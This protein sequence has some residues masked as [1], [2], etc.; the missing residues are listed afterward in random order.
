MEHR[1]TR[2][3]LRN[4]VEEGGKNGLIWAVF[5]SSC[6]KNEQDVR[7]M[8]TA[9]TSVLRALT[10]LGPVLDFLWVLVVL[11]GNVPWLHTRTLQPRSIERRVL[12]QRRSQT[13]RKVV[14]KKR[15]LQIAKGY[16]GRQNLHLRSRLRTQ[17]QRYTRPR[18]AISCCCSWAAVLCMSTH[19]A[20]GDLSGDSC[21]LFLPL[22][23]CNK[24]KGEND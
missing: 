8:K 22:S 24:A 13:R 3:R 11:K 19:G 12:L 2:S 6:E 7:R 21:T 5:W 9:K 18:H 4:A 10:R 20:L 23:D 15:L 1:C 14:P 16:T 17:P